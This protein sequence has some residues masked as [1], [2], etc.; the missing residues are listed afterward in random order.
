LSGNS[1]I[2]DR[3][4]HNLSVALAL[5]VLFEV[6]FFAALLAT[7]GAFNGGQPTTTPPSAQAYFAIGLVIT[8]IVIVFT[9]RMKA[10]ARA[11]DLRQLGVL[12]V[13][14]W[15]LVA[16]LF[17]GILPGIYLH[18]VAVLMKLVDP[19]EAPTDTIES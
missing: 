14:M 18:S 17:S 6:S 1:A 5:L 19:A 4:A 2:Y 11:H 8:P 10:A 13:D 15:A 12:R 7:F 3:L 9:L 16:L